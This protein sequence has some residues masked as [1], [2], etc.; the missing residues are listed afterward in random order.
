MQYDVLILSD[1]RPGHYRQSEGVAAAI[2]RHH[3]VAVRWI[4]INNR[5][6]LPKALIPK[7][8]RRLSPRAALRHLHAIDPE[9][10]HPPALIVSAGGLTLGANVALAHLLG[11]PNVFCG[12]TR[13]FPLDAFSLV[14][15]DDPSQ[16]GPP[17]VCI[18]PKPA[19]FDPDTLPTPAASLAK[20]DL[21]IGVLVGGP[22]ETSDFGPA[23]WSGLMKLIEA[24][25]SETEATVTLATSPRTPDVAYQAITKT[26][27]A[28]TRQFNLIDFRTAGPGSLGPALGADLL[29]VTADSMTMMTEAALSRRP[30]IALR[31]ARTTPTRDEAAMAW[32]VA[33]K[34]LAVCDIA[35]LAADTLL[36]EA[37]ALQPM[38]ENHLDRLSRSVLP[39][40]KHRSVS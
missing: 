32:L 24:L 9:T 16:A 30:A 23:D 19:T 15:T 14:L 31:P 21:H 12:A 35:N 27:A 29:V 20:P 28:F 11:S 5:W 2:S 25:M 22:T 38:T 39:L 8:A 18:A 34:W 7:L 40:L 33:E 1:G 26:A 36:K 17:N 13:H 37:S 3:P 10:L 6:R 4:E